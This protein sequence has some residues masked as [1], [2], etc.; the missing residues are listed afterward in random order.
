VNSGDDY[1]IPIVCPHGVFIL[2]E[3]R[4]G[5]GAGEERN[6]PTVK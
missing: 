1:D 3:W 5:G 4:P 2:V 6:R